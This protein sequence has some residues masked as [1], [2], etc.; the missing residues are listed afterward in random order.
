MRYGDTM[1]NLLSLKGL[2]LLLICCV[3]I[4]TWSGQDVMAYDNY[5]NPIRVRL[6]AVSGSVNVQVSYSSYEILNSSGGRVAS[7]S[8]GESVSL[9]AGQTLSS[10]NG[11]GRFIYQGKEYRGDL[12]NAGGYIVNRLGMEEY[13]YS[14]IYLEIGGY[15]PDIEAL[16]AQAVASRSLGCYAK[17]HPRT[18]YYDVV[19][20]TSD[21]AYGG[22]SGENYS[23]SAASVSYR[24][25]EACKSTLNQVMYYDGSLIKGIYCA[26]T[27]G[28]SADAA[29]VWG[30]DYDY[31][32][33]RYVPYDSQSFVADNY[34]ASSDSTYQAV[35]MPTGY[36]WRKTFTY[37]DLT[38]KVEKY[39]SK[40]IGVL[41]DIKIDAAS[42]GYVKEISFVGDKATVTLTGEEVRS[43]LSLRSGSFSVVLGESLSAAQGF[44][45]TYLDKNNFSRF[46]NRSGNVANFQGR[47]YGHS[48]GMSQWAACVMAYKGMSYQEILTYFYG[49]ESNGTALSIESFR[50]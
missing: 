22:Y 6:D 2:L 28:Y 39:S 32:Q 12:I 18:N 34:S 33:G 42:G 29:D 17:H 44:S 47:G 36:Q 5:N 20:T 26:N 16:K 9:S 41:T 45:L 43:C 46:L 48:V 10:V 21:Q 37:A 3:F 15:S 35:K 50:G 25:R 4:F 7:I 23:T 27:G 24:I 14:V 40:T 38:A 11:Y 49:G 19:A 31:L 13:L 8:Q 1:R 30:G